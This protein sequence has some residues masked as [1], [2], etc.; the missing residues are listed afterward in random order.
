MS[1]KHLFAA[2][3]AGLGVTAT[4]A[5][6]ATPDVWAKFKDVTL[7]QPRSR[8]EVLAELEIY[9]RSGL[10]ELE[11]GEATDTFSRQYRLASAR[12]AAMRS[13]QEFASLVQNIAKR[14]GEVVDVAAAPSTTSP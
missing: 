4:L 10:A 1:T 6:E 5:Q 12:Y 2:L 3:V 11:H 7:P 8:A 9:R 13:S 14:R